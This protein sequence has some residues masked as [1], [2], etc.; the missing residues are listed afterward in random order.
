MSHERLSCS[1][2]S[3]LERLNEQAASQAAPELLSS[4]FKVG[5][6]RF[7]SIF[8]TEQYKW[9]EIVVLFCSLVNFAFLV[10][11]IFF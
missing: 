1:G 3:V 8:R 4:H 5:D 6:E 7:A 9:K 2:Q 10:K 11:E